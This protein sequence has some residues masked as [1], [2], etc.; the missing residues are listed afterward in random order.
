MVQALTNDILF[1]E[2]Q[3]CARTKRYNA[4]IHIVIRK[5]KQ[6]YQLPQRVIR[7]GLTII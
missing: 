3:K 2:G 1:F 7:E 4:A 5:V 6:T